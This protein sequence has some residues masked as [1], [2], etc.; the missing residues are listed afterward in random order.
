MTTGGRMLLA[1]AAFLFV[2]TAVYW[3]T[4]YEEAGSVLLLLSAALALMTG[5]YLVMATRS[6]TGDEE[7]EDTGPAV[8]GGAVGGGE[9]EA[10][11]FL[12]HASVWPLGVGAGSV[13]LANGLALGLWA[14]VPGVII[15]AG[16]LFG[17]ARQSRRR[18]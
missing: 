1:V 16:S 6:A 3:F 18:D 4:S 13:V 15:L 8:E 9:G 10:E 11:P 12:P 5:G 7:A 17:Y 2:V 14:V